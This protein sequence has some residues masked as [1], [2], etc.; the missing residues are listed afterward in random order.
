MVECI[1]KRKMHKQAQHRFWHTAKWNKLYHLKWNINT[2]DT[3]IPL[4][5]CHF[6]PPSFFCNPICIN[7]LQ[8][9]SGV[10]THNSVKNEVSIL[11]NGWVIANYSVSR[12]PFC[13]PSW[14][15]WSYLRQT[16]TTDVRCHYAQFSENE[17]S[18]LINGRV[19]DNYSVS[20]PQFFPP[21]WNL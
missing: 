21:S 12:P 8:L 17:V 4:H 9:M 19:T 20:R 3:A 18:I 13:L 15:L 6:C 7:L 16:S 5:G 11:I 10:I 2:W 14:N 1:P